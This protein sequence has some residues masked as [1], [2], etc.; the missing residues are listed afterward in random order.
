MLH[1]LTVHQTLPLQL[2]ATQALHVN[3]TLGTKEKMEARAPSAKQAL[4]KMVW[5]QS[6]VQAVHLHQYLLLAAL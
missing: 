1:A 3:V 5:G 2:A 6:L 4:I